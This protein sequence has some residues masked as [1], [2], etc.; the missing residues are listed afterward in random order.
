M[1]IQG[2]NGKVVLVG[3]EGRLKVESVSIPED[4]HLNFEEKVFSVYF[5][6]DPTGA[7][8]YFFYLQNT[9]ALDLYITDIRISVSSATAVYYEHVIGTPSYTSETACDVT[10]RSLGSAKTLPAIANYDVNI[11]GLTSQ[12]VIFFEEQATANERKKLHTTS[13][14]LIPQGQAVAFRRGAA[15]GTIECVVSVVEAEG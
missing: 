4:K 13:N 8:D 1:Q 7:D 9:G 2:P 3:D 11:T 10:N 15:T 6:V 12:G 5:E 14:I